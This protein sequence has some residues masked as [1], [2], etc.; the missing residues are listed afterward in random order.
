MFNKKSL[1]FDFLL[2]LLLVLLLFASLDYAQAVDSTK[3]KQHHRFDYRRLD[4]NNL[5]PVQKY[6]QPKEEVFPLG[7]PDFIGTSGT[8]HLNKITTGTGVWTELNPK[9]P[10]VTYLGLHFVNKDTG[11]ACGQSGAVIKTMDGGSSWT[12]L[13][14]P[15]T[16]LLL[17]THS[18]NGQIVLVTGYDGII[19]RSSD[20]G[21]NFIQVTSGVGNGYDLWGVQMLN[22][23][24]GWVCGLNQTLLKTTDAGLTWQSVST[25]L[26]QHY[27]SLDFIDEQYGMIACGGGKIL[28]TTDGG[29]G[30]TQIQ[31][32]D[33]RALY[34][35]DVIDS[36]HI[37][38]AGANGKNV[39]SSD[40]GVTWISNSD[41][42]VFSATNCIDFINADTGYTVQ[43]VYNIRKTTNRGQSWFGLPINMT[44]EWQA[45][46]KTND[47][48]ITWMKVQDAPS[49]ND[50]LFLDSLAGFIGSNLIYKTTN[51]GVTWYVP[52][53]GQGGAG[54]IFFV[55][56][57]IG[58]A[59]RSNVIYK[60]TDRG[61]N[62]FTQLTS[63]TGSF[64]SIHLT[65]SLT[66][67]ASIIGRR[68][69]KTTNGGANWIE[70]TD[71]EL[72][73]TVDVF[74]KDYNEG[75]FANE[76]DNNLLNT[77]DGGIT[78]E[79][80][81]GV[82]GPRRFSFFPDTSRWWTLGFSNLYE[83]TDEGNNWNDITPPIPM[84]AKFNAPFNW[85]GY[86]VG[87]G[88]YIIKYIDSLYIPVELVAFT[89]TIEGHNVM[90]EWI[91]A[92]EL[93]NYGFELERSFDEYNWMTIG[94]LT[95]KGTTSEKSLYN[96]EDQLIRPIQ[97]YRLKQ[98]DYNGNFN[99]SRIIT[100]ET[101]LSNFVLFQNYPNP[102]NPSTNISF[103]VPE[104]TKVKIIIYSISGEV[105][106]D[107]VNEE[108][109]KGIYTIKIDLNDLATGVYFYRITT[110]KGYSD[111]KKLVLLK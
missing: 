108:K 94:F 21:E 105:V 51:G 14:T 28:K 12:I 88:G 74:F 16:N 33:T 52:N 100:I 6:A 57:E 54:K 8:N 37:A 75:W 24:L 59:V 73:G 23:T 95:G 9:V 1:K 89:S 77:T 110:S 5:P 7:Y 64:T 39:Y 61:E 102:A 79:V 40:S 72:W 45:L 111:V 50:L 26:N 36:L 71:L 87:S 55:N 107:L 97:F 84:F 82:Y 60:S 13:S 92:S 44:S 69:F 86:G 67:W 10:R 15:V 78:W 58:W 27:W 25:G 83:T 20:G 47:G 98:I 35:I 106:K 53:G 99:Y 29:S 2:S 76:Y 96:F 49:G 11:W 63:L 101:S 91:T 46:Y 41:I 109:D 81:S 38:A 90:L 66:G 56:Q 65:D 70:Q 62:W 42:P 68:P 43:D 34:T 3:D 85:V 19:L 104:K 18:Y 93:N 80:V 103:S 32:G 4:P 17:K 22:D 48:G 30:W 31:A